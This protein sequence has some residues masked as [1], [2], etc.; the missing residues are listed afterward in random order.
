[1]KY[2]L[3][4]EG[5]NLANFLA[6]T[7]DLSTIRGG[8]LLLLRSVKWVEDVVKKE[9][10]DIHL[11]AI[12][13]GAS[14]G[15][16]S[17]D[18]DENGADKLRETVAGFL[19]QHKKLGYA[20][21]VV[22]VQ[23]A[24]SDFLHGKEAVFARNRWR[25]WQ[26][27]TCILPEHNDNPKTQVCPLDRIRPGT[28]QKPIKGKQKW[29][30]SSAAIRRSY[31]SSKKQ[32]FY[33]DE[34]KH[35]FNSDFKGKFVKEFEALTNDESRGNLHH[36]MAVVYLDGNGF[37]KIQNEYC[38]DE[39]AQQSF[40]KTVKKYRADALKEILEK[41]G[42]AAGYRTATCE[43]RLETLLWGGDEVIWVVPAWKGWEV[44]GMF[45]AISNNWHFD[46]NAPLTHAGGLVFCHHNAPIHRIV[47]LTKSLA[48]AVK[49]E[50]EES[51]EAEGRD[52]NKNLFQ[53][54][55]LE[56]FDHIGSDLDQYRKTQCPFTWKLSLDGRNMVKIDEKFRELKEDFP[57]NKVIAGV[58]AALRDAG[59]GAEPGFHDR[60]ITRL[61]KIVPREVETMASNF[62]GYFGGSP[63]L[64]LHLAD[65][66]DYIAEEES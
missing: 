54:L 5:V 47:E 19:R 53:Y 26:Q 59:S 27:P 18:A 2:Y 49:T 24:D 31:G 64:W 48:D 3:R 35:Y 57:R 46:N 8:G 56:S 36:K 13:T 17:F 29:I 44:L 23:K 60:F 14:N 62:N 40:D 9:F 30:S 32:K 10:P 6:D 63:G 37:G 11:Q 43:L 15:L 21:F 52:I 61:T 12:S 58:H 50:I 34:M 38:R 22:D 25:Q 1:M 42:S 4:I 65:L 16:F 39:N 41:M 51:N 45:Y 20:T 7:Q 66:W 55:V 28:E 33:A